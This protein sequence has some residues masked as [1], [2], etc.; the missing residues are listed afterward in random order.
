MTTQYLIKRGDTLT[1]IAKKYNLSLNQLIAA[2]PHLAKNPDLIYAGDTLLIP[3]TNERETNVSNVKTTSVNITPI[4]AKHTSET[5]IKASPE[6]HADYYQTA[7]NQLDVDRAA[8]KAV[9]DVESC[10]KAFIAK[11][12]PAILFEA[13]IFSRLTQ[14]QYDEA[15]PHLSSRKWNP[16]LYKGGLKEYDRLAEAKLLNETEAL[17]SASWGKFQIMGFNYQLAGFKTI[18][19]FVAAMCNSEEAQLMAFVSFIQAH[20]SMLQA[21]RNHDWAKF[22][23]CYNGPAYAKNRYDSKLAAAYQQALRA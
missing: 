4:K 18:N 7:A 19:D 13:H 1:T 9:A 3:D 6:N 2:N 8:V 11:H 23:K 17:K 10:G 12:K 22:A 21:L 5:Q 15:Y 14:H 20:K 16:K